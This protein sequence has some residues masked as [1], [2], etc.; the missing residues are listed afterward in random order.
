LENRL[1]SA[2]WKLP[3]KM[4]YTAANTP[5]QNAL[6]EVK[7]THLAAKA[8]AAMHAAEIPRKRRLEFF[9]E[10]I[11]TMT[12]LDWL[13]LITIN[14]VKKTRIEHYG[15]PLPL[16]SIYVLGEKQES[17]KDGKIGDQGVTGMFVG[18][19]QNHKGDCY[20]MWNP[21]T[22]K[23]TETCDVVFLNRTF[24]RTHTMPVH[25]KQSTD[26][27]D[28]NS[29]QLDERGGTIT[30]NFVTGD[31]AAMVESVDS[32]VPDTPMVNNNL[33][34]LKYGCTYRCTKYYHPATGR[35]IGVEA[36]ALANYY[37]CLKDTD[38]EMEFANVGAGIGGEFENTIELKPIKYKE[39]INRPDGKAR[40]KEIENEHDRMVKNNALEPVKKSLLP[41]G[42]KV[43]DST[44]ACKKKNTRKLHG[45]LNACGFKVEGVHFNGTST[46]AIVMNA[47]TIQIVLILTYD[48]G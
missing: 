19:T 5:Q 42:T 17:S 21:K 16:P 12:K 47:G 35:M 24:F 36:A 28:L 27:E 31:D 33:E 22:K 18:Y 39:A 41:K 30:E 11:M 44:W 7:F 6:V 25:K 34:Q 1:H 32:S 20:R 23:V 40:E 13:K 14:K 26:D 4:E 46:H 48:Y 43:I 37:Q 38:G 2:D 29:V 8:R 10:V 45:H 9:P 15:L 3:V